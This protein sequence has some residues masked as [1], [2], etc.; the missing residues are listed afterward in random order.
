MQPVRRK[1]VLGHIAFLLAGTILGWF[2]DRAELGL[3]VAA[4]VALAWNIR[5]LLSFEAAVRSNDFTSFRY[6]EGIWSQLYSKFSYQRRQSQ[7]YKKNYRQ[8]VKE[9][10]KSTNAM[11]DGGI[12]LSEGFEIVLCNKAAQRLGGFRR[13]KDRGQRVDNFLR[14]PAFTAYLDA[15]ESPRRYD[16]R[17]SG[18]AH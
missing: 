3:L 5:K 4:L 13:R 2:Y 16:W 1:I 7:Q 11:P 18:R 17:A 12:I 9:V 6:D 8:L 14:D 10:R 15:G